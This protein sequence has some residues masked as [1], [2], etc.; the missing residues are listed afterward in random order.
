M[1]K[2]KDVEV[3][4][5]KEPVAPQLHRALSPFDEIDRLVDSLWRHRWPRLLSD[6]WPGWTGTGQLFD[7]PMPK[8]DVLD[9]GD[10]L[11]V[12]AEL[13][14]VNK[15]DL[16]VSILQQ[17]ITIR[18]KT[19]REE[20]S[21]QGEYFHREISRGEF[22]RAVTLPTDVDAANAKARFENGVL[23]ISLPK[24]KPIERHSIE[25]A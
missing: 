18:G 1:S 7:R 6:E 11:I 13:P 24:L 22:Q 14:G 15:E 17:R 23:T 5:S 9:L 19:S 10:Q 12:S 3:K 16:D 25:V 20:H 2:N 21:E 8:V 4:N